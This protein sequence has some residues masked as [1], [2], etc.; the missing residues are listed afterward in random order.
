MKIL[1]FAYACAPEG[2]KESVMGWSW[3]ITYLEKGY[4][5]HCLTSQASAERI[6]WALEHHLDVTPQLYPLE[7]PRWLDSACEK[8][9]GLMWNSLSYLAFLREATRQ[10]KRLASSHDFAWAHQ[11]SWNKVWMGSPLWRLDV[12]LVLG[13][14]EGGEF[15]PAGFA[16]Y[17]DQGWEQEA[18]RR[19]VIERLFDHYPDVKATLRRADL[20]LATNQETR[21]MARAMGARQV[22]YW[23]GVALSADLLPASPPQR[24]AGEALQLIW[25]GT[26]APREGL[27]LA[28]E[29]LSLVPPG[30]PVH[31]HVYGEG[32]WEEQVKEWI[33][34]Y[35]VAARCT[36]HGGASPSALEE[37]LLQSDALLCTTLREP[38][39]L[40]ALEAMAHGLPLIG[41]D[42]HGLHT[43]L[44]HEAG[45]T[46]EAATPRKTSAALAGA[47]EYCYHHPAERIR[48]GELG[49]QYLQA[50][51]LGTAWGQFED[52]LQQLGL[53]PP[54][55]SPEPEERD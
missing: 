53:M 2:D 8:N 40:P 39:D 31:L 33:E 20:V 6:H 24:E 7:L 44:P 49:R 22:R 46:V 47:I 36:W 54:V 17:F 55:A 11:V 32:E 38:L 52:L 4:E 48:A 15:V 23:G 28:L 37:A 43:W 14:M 45:F 9:E 41:L 25:K 12:P 34:R 5:V 21:S 30:L 42:L 18:K 16:R 27:P 35:D 29:A 26:M 19:R 3:L 1:L 13:P 50:Q 10:A 51:Q